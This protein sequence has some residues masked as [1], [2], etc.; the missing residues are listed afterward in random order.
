MQ[1]PAGFRPTRPVSRRRPARGRTHAKKI[2]AARE[3]DGDEIGPLA[4][5]S[6]DQLDFFFADSIAST[7]RRSMFAASCFRWRIAPTCSCS[8]LSSS[9]LE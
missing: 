1:A 3:G 6:A 9:D 4:T 7:L 5:W 2:A 8:A